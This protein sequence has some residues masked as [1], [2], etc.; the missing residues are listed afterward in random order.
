MPQPFIIKNVLEEIRKLPNFPNLKV[1]DLSCGEGEILVDLF[2]DGCNVRGSR[3]QSNDYIIKE[4]RTTGQFPI[5]EKVDLTT[6]LPYNDGEFDVVILTEVV[7][8]LETY[9]KVIREAARIIKK[10]GVLIITTPNIYRLHSRWKFFLTGSHK[11]INRR[12]SWDIGADQLYAYHISPLDLSL[13]SSVAHQEGISLTKIRTTRIK[14]R[15]GIWFLFFPIFWLL[16][17]IE[18]R[19]GKQGSLRRKGE[20]VLRKLMTSPQI[21]YSEQLMV[22]MQKN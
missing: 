21:F 1:L 11:L 16:A 19:K 3:Y 17:M 20:D 22:M 12:L 13:F 4:D 9:I 5:D 15:H 18:Y 2:A 8:H 10:S 14:W 7:E 6:R